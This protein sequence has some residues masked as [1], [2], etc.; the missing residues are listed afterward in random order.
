MTR[1]VADEPLLRGKPALVRQELRERQRCPPRSCGLHRE[2][3][4]ASRLG[5]AGGALRA[6]A[7]RRAS[8]RRRRG[9]NLLEIPS[10][11]ELG[12]KRARPLEV[13]SSIAL[14]QRFIEPEP[15]PHLPMCAGQFWNGSEPLGCDEGAFP[16]QA[17]LA[18]APEQPE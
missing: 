14:A 2:G 13:L 11:A 15:A 3:L 7:C 8:T 4:V 5:M 9:V 12:K 10:E 16:P 6:G 1:Q 18:F 17:G